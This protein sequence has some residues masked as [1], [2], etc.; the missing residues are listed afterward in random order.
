MPHGRDAKQMI[1]DRANGT[2]FVEQHGENVRYVPPWKR[3][4][5]WD[6][7]RWRID[8]TLAV[9][10]MGKATGDALWDAAKAGNSLELASEAKRAQSVVGH[11]AMLEMAASEESIVVL[12]G[13]LDSDPW[14]LNTPSGT[15]DLRT[16][17]AY[18]AKREDLITKMTAACFDPEAKCPR[19]KQFLGEV[20][21]RADFTTDRDVIAYVLRLVGYSLTG[22]VREQMFAILHG[23]GANGK[24]VFTNTLHYMLGDYGGVA[25]A[26][27]L[28]SKKSDAHP[29]ELANLFGRR[30]VISAE[31]DAGRRLDEA[32]VKNITGSD[33]IAARRMREDWWE[34][35]PQHKMMLATNHKP[36]IRGTDD[37]IWRRIHLIPFNRK[38]E[39]DEQDVDLEQK[40]REEWPGILALAVRGCLEW[41]NRGLRPPA[42]VVEATKDYRDENN[43]LRRFVDEECDTHLRDAFA[44]AADLFAAYQ[45]WGAREG[46]D[47]MTGVAFG[48]ELTAQGFATETRRVAQ[49]PTKVRLHIC[50]RRTVDNSPQVGD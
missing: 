14:L 42:A 27:L 2:R 16:G 31:T 19:W 41:Q 1:G 30:L 25:A 34:Y 11:R 3:W 12:P 38:F 24:G 47:L 26:N 8:D 6:G 44:P 23:N 7:H 21:T 50:L 5:V 40:L 13:A 4:I 33:P 15:V 43:T 17:E 20:F 28:L 36:E 32:L 10:R 37:G 22:S 29:T 39:D 35:A 9:Q 48:R 46:V 49:K 18:N 45:G